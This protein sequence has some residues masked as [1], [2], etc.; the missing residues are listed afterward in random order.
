MVIFVMFGVFCRYGDDVKWLLQVSKKLGTQYLYQFCVC[1]VNS[2]ASPFVLHGVAIEVT[3][4]LARNN[5]NMF[6][7]HLRS[8]MTP[9]VQKCQ[10]M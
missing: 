5:P 2:I 9:L 8:A 10:Q 4:Y 7:Q 6:I 1:V 3:H